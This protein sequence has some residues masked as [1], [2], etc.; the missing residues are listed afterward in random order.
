[1]YN[2]FGKSVDELT[3][4][5]LLETLPGKRESWTFEYKGPDKISDGEGIAKSIASFANMYGGWLFIGIDADSGNEPELADI[6]G[7][8]GDEGCLTERV[9]QMCNSNLSPSP[10]VAC[11]V[12]ELES[13]GAV[14]VVHVPQSP[15]P[16][17][18]L[19]K[20]GKVY[21]RSGDTTSPMDIVQ[22]RQTLDRLY[23]RAREN[24]DQVEALAAVHG[25]GALFIEKVRSA[26]RSTSIAL[27][28]DP[29]PVGAFAIVS[30]PAVAVPTLL[31]LDA[32]PS[33]AVDIM[34]RARKD[35]DFS[36]ADMLREFAS[37][38]YWR[39]WL[40]QYR[41]YT[42][43]DRYCLFYLDCFAHVGIAKVAW[44]GE[45]SLNVAACAV[46]ECV[47]Y[48]P[49]LC[50]TAEAVYRDLG[51]LG[52]VNVACRVSFSDQEVRAPVEI[53]AP[54]L[55]LSKTVKE[56]QRQMKLDLRRVAGLEDQAP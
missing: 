54:A 43:T 53:T 36:L 51:Y 41:Y 5:D 29:S 50:A 2:P 47:K 16:P 4:S 55:E 20:S 7:I 10:Y 30:Y 39:Q 26:V 15:N 32:T 49:A 25:R 37:P 23:D 8:A 22:D 14:I 48:L 40:D 13:G 34:N 44:P 19:M 56:M 28:E 1:M 12:V 33:L 11:S 6:E 27:M 42:V 31:E 18:I 21:V 9:Y 17:H 45:G 35:A 38:V 46:T 24:R 52:L 3:E